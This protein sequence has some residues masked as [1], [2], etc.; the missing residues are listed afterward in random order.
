MPTLKSVKK[1]K[2]PSEQK[3]KHKK[4]S[5]E[6][7]GQKALKHYLGELW[8]FCVYLRADFR[9][10]ACGI[11]C[12]PGIFGLHSHHVVKR[13][14][15]YAMRYDPDNGMG[16]CYKCHYR[17]DRDPLWALPFLDRR[18]L[19]HVIKRSTG[20]VSLQ[21]WKTILESRIRALLRKKVNLKDGNLFLI[22]E[23][24]KTLELEKDFRETVENLL[25]RGLEESDKRNVKNRI[26]QI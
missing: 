17:A 6:K 18:R 19:D 8:R 5:S 21:E 20:K 26:F 9:C 16:L 10:E 23:Y 7:K 2:R 25:R 14:L 3:K 22:M 11:P 4:K 12:R 13:R 1:L 24:L 15:S